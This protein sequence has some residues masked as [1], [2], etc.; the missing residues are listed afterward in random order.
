[1]IKTLTNKFLQQG[2]LLPYI[3]VGGTAAFVDLAIFVIFAKIVGIPYL[4]VGAFGF[5]L[6]T[7]VNYMLC[8]R[9]VFDSGVRY[10][11]KKEVFYIFLISILGL[12]LHQ[13]LLAM[14]VEVFEI[15]IVISKINA[16]GVVF[17]WNYLMRKHFV[18][19][20]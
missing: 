17:L 8:V 1:M 15:E 12:A 18:F 13:L 2:T 14:F 11:R 3:L 4:W 7:T 6:A 19:M 5:C 9:F 20:R 10:D 16:T